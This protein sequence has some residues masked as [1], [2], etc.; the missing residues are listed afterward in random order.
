MRDIRGGIS[1]D[2]LHTTAP[3]NKSDA[4]RDEKRDYADNPL[5]RLRTERCKPLKPPG[6]SGTAC[7]R[8][9]MLMDVNKRAR[10]LGRRCMSPI[11]G[12]SDS[13]L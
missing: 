7:A 9:D 3:R 12:H 5:D 2:F 10:T 6:L 4:P 11:H 8:R 13:N 1:A